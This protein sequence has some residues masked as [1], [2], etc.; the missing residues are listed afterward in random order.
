MM[1]I[2]EKHK[3]GRRGFSYGECDV[4]KAQPLAG[5][6]TRSIEARLP[7]LSELDVVRH[8]TNLSRLNY[9]PWIQIFIRWDPAR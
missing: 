4:S 9:T 2:F 6:F 8:Y 7:C 5:R 1:L 3:A